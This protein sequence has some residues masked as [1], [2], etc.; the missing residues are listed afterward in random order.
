MPEVRHDRAPAMAVPPSRRG[1]R[2]RPAPPRRRARAPAPRRATSRSSCASR[3]PARD[4]VL[5]G[6]RAA[7]PATPPW[8]RSSACASRSAS[9]TTCAPF[10]DRFR[11][12]PLIGAVGARAG[13][14]CGSAAAPSRSR[15]SRGRSPSSSSS[16]RAPPRSSGASC[17]ASA[18]AAP[19]RGLRDLPAAATRRGHG[20]RAAAELRPSAGPRARA[21]PRRA[22]G[23][24]GPRRPARARPR[25]R[26]GGGCARSRGS[27]RGRSR[28]S[29]LHGQGRYDLVPAGDLAYLKLVGRLADGQP[30]RARDRGRG[31][32]A[33]SRPTR[34]WAGLAAMHALAARS[35]GPR[36]AAAYMPSPGQELVRQ[37]AGRVGGCVTQPVV[38]PSSCRRRPTRPGPCSRTACDVSAGKNTGSVA[39]TLASLEAPV[40]VR[41]GAAAAASMPLLGSLLAAPS[42]PGASAGRKRRTFAPPF[43]VERVLARD[44]H[45]LVV[46]RHAGLSPCG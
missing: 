45:E 21:A 6:A 2:R 46:G 7:R 38:R 24:D 13:R 17:S 5:F 40:E 32:R 25:A 42:C 35:R 8:R 33:S 11:D 34:S 20:A 23:R 9:T 1:A 4:E 31:P 16:S 10:H 44:E 12:D 29:A 22:R 19:R 28:C 14:G 26:P 43:C 39:L 30:A 36:V 18:G 15:R 3:S 37:R 27:A 41:V